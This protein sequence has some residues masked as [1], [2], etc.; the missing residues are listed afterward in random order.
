MAYAVTE[1]LQLFSYPSQSSLGVWSTE[2]PL[3]IFFD[4]LG[5]HRLFG[6]Y[7][8]LDPVFLF[9]FLRSHRLIRGHGF[10]TLDTARIVRGHWSRGLGVAALQPFSQ[11]V[12]KQL[13]IVEPGDRSPKVSLQE[14]PPVLDLLSSDARIGLGLMEPPGNE[15]NRRHVQ[16]RISS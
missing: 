7:Q 5:V 2:E 16:D 3:E 12:S 10:A 13:R 4:R 14:I 6:E 9:Q 8:L 15:K 11:E 1:I